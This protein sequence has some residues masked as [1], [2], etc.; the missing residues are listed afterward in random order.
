MIFIWL[1]LL[2]LLAIVLFVAYPVVL[3]VCILIMSI[4]QTII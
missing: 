2:V 4:F 3:F 1:V